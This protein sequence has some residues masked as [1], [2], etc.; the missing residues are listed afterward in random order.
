MVHARSGQRISQRPA[1]TTWVQGFGGSVALNFGSWSPI[2][3]RKW[4]SR[5]L[6]LVA[7]VSLSY[8]CIYQ[9]VAILYGIRATRVRY[10]QDCAIGGRGRNFSKLVP[11]FC[12]WLEIAKG[13]KLFGS[14]MLMCECV[15]I[16]ICMQILA[17]AMRRGRKPRP[18]PMAYDLWPRPRYRHTSTYRHT[19]ICV[20]VCEYSAPVFCSK[21]MF[22]TLVLKSDTV[23]LEE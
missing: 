19:Y 10:F 23:R 1:A 7:A 12:R 21:G 22:T 6:E 18:S 3:Y 9:C 20:W 17:C 8:R 15:Y 16:Y 13:I 4:G 14:K 2:G 5:E 11:I